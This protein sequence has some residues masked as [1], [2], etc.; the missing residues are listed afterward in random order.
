MVDKIREILVIC[1]NLF[2][3]RISNVVVN[4]RNNENKKAQIDNNYRKKVFVTKELNRIKRPPYE[5]RLLKYMEEW[6]K[7][8]T[9]V[10]G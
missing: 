1:N 7:M 3:F 8:E 4:L 9:N 5:I 10:I 6:G 2:K